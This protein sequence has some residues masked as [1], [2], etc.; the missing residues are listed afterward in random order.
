MEERPPVKFE[1]R[2]SQTGK[3]IEVT[4]ILCYDEKWEENGLW[5]VPFR[6]PAGELKVVFTPDKELV[7]IRRPLNNA[8]NTANDSLISA[9]AKIGYSGISYRDTISQ[10]Q[11][12]TICGQIKCAQRGISFFPGDLQ[13]PGLTLPENII[14]ELR[15]RDEIPRV[16]ILPPVLEDLEGF[17]LNVDKQINR[18]SSGKS[19]LRDCISDVI[20]QAPDSRLAKIKELNTAGPTIP[21]RVYPDKKSV[22]AIAKKLNIEIST[23][24]MIDAEK[25]REEQ[26]EINIPEIGSTL[27]KLF[28]KRLQLG[29]KSQRL[30]YLDPEASYQPLTDFPTVTG[31]T[32]EEIISGLPSKEYRLEVPDNDY[33]PG[34]ISQVIWEFLNSRAGEIRHSGSRPS[35]GENEKKYLDQ[36]R[37]CVTRGLPVE[38]IFMNFSPKFASPLISGYSLLPDLSNLMAL[39]HLIDVAK[40]VQEIY[41]PGIKFIIL[42]EGRL[43]QNLGQFTDGEAHESLEQVKYFSRVL[44]GK[45]GVSGVIEIADARESVD[46]LGA[47]FMN[48]LETEEENLDRAYASDEDG[49]FIRKIEEWRTAFAMNIID[50]DRLIREYGEEHPPLALADWLRVIHHT[51]PSGGFL[52]RVRHYADQRTRST[53]IDYFAFR[54][55][56]YSGGTG[57]R[58][59]LTDY[60][61]AIPITVRADRS[62]LSL[63]LI[64]GISSYPHHGITVWTGEK[65]EITG[66]MDLARYPG[67][68]EG[69]TLAG[70]NAPGRTPFYYTLKGVDCPV[71][72]RPAKD[73]KQDG[74][75][76][77]IL[78]KKGFRML[79][80]W[81]DRG[82]MDSRLYLAED[83]SGTKV[84]IKYSS[85]EGFGGN[86]R[87]VLRKEALRLKGISEQMGALSGSIFPEVIEYFDDEN[88]TYYVMNYFSDTQSVDDYLAGLPS[89]ESYSAEAGRLVNKLLDIMSEKVY[90]R[91]TETTPPDYISR[92]HLDR[93]REGVQ[94]LI[95]DKSSIFVDF[96]K[97][98]IFKAGGVEYK[99]VTDFFRK[100]FSNE[101]VVVNGVELLN[102]PSI[103]RAISDNEEAIN[104]ALNPE[105]IPKI[106]HGD[107]YFRNVL[108]DPDGELFLVDPYGKRPVNA[109]ETELGRLMLSYFADFLG[110]GDYDINVRAAEDGKLDFSLFYNGADDDSIRG[111]A[112]A[113]DAMLEIYGN[114]PGIYSWIKNTEN[115]QAHVLLLEAIHIF[116]VAASKFSST[117]PP[118]KLTLA[119]YIT[120]LV[121][122]NKVLADMGLIDR[123]YGS[124]SSPMELF[125]PGEY[126]FQTV[127]FMRR[128]APGANEADGEK[129]LTFLIE[130]F[131]KAGKHG[132]DKDTYWELWRSFK[133][134]VDD[135]IATD[136]YMLDLET[137]KVMILTLKDGR[138]I[139][140]RMVSGEFTD[141]IEPL[142]ALHIKGGSKLEI[143]HADDALK[144]WQNI[145]FPDTSS[146]PDLFE[147]YSEKDMFESLRNGSPVSFG[148]KSYQ[149]TDLLGFGKESKVFKAREIETGREV[150]LKAGLT[151]LE[152]ESSD[153]GVMTSK[154]KDSTF[155]GYFPSYELFDKEKNV[156]VMELIKGEPLDAHITQRLE[157]GES[158]EK[159]LLLFSGIMI[160]IC[161]MKEKYGV[162]YGQF[163]LRNILIDKKGDKRFI[164]PSYPLPRD[165]YDLLQIIRAGAIMMEKFYG[166]RDDE[167]PPKVKGAAG[168]D[169]LKKVRISGSIWE[170]FEEAELPVEPMINTKIK[171][172]IRKCLVPDTRIE[173]LRDLREEL[174]GLCDVIYAYHPELRPAALH[175]GAARSI[176]QA[177]LKEY[178]SK[179]YKALAVDYNNTLEQDGATDRYLM[180]KIAELLEQDIHVAVIT[181]RRATWINTFVEEIRPFLPDEDALKRLHFYTSEG[182][183]GCNVGTRELYYEHAFDRNLMVKTAKVIKKE[184]PRLDFSVNYRTDGYRMNFDPIMDVKRLNE[185]FE[186]LGLPVIALTSG[187]SIDVLP[188]GINKGVA[189]ADFAARLGISIAD[190]ARIADQGQKYGNDNSLLSGPGS[191]SVDRCE[192]DSDQAGTAE[193]LGLKGIFATA[194]LLDNLRFHE[195]GTDHR[196]ML[197][198]D[199][200]REHGW[201]SKYADGSL[202]SDRKFV[203][204]AVKRH[205]WALRYADGSLQK[206][207]EIVLA[208]V[209][210]FGLALQYAGGSLRNDKEIVM[211]A[212]KTNRSAFKHADESLK[213]D[214][215]FVLAVVKENGRALEHADELLRND[216][217]I[218]LAAAIR[219][220]R[221]PAEYA[222]RSLWENRDFVLAQVKKD[223]SALECAAEPLKSDK[224]IV[225]TAVKQNRWA[226]RYAHGSLREDREVVLAGVR[227][228]G[229]DLASADESLW[230]DKEF[231]LSVLI[232]NG[233]AFRF[234][235]GSLKKDRDFVLAAV[236]VNGWALKYADG[237][238]RKD[239]EI[240]LAAVKG[241]GAALQ[242][243]D[244]SLRKDKEIVVT[245]VTDNG[246]ALKFADGSLKG[247]QDI[248]RAAKIEAETIYGR[249]APPVQADGRSLL[250]VPDPREDPFSKDN[251][252]E[253]NLLVAWS[254]GKDGCLA[255]HRAMKDKNNRLAC[256]LNFTSRQSA[257]VSFH[258]IPPKLLQMQVEALGVPLLQAETTPDGY[259]EE[260]KAAV[261][262][263]V[264]PH[265]IDAMVFGDIYVDEHKEWVGQVCEDAGIQAIEPLW[266]ENTEDLLREIID[267]GFEVRIVSV[268]DG[269]IDKKWVGRKIDHEFLDH[270][271]ERGLDP[272][273]EYGEYHSFVTDGPIFTRRIELL[274]TSVVKRWKYW[275][276]DI[277]KYRSVPKEQG[278]SSPAAEEKTTSKIKKETPPAAGTQ[279]PG[280]FVD[281]KQEI[282]DLI[283]SLQFTENQPALRIRTIKALAA[284]NR[285]P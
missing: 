19:G 190:I 68:F 87:P 211:E 160:D 237:A 92:F 80:D 196:A 234:A 73:Q 155:A 35:Y 255:L 207:R 148:G 2:S 166:L 139:G 259:Q 119:C 131:E 81:S 48:E 223:G 53:A 258:E 116:V 123:K 265:E 108:R 63:Q 244:T 270:L 261:S 157:A 262:S 171:E 5:V 269:L 102:F 90:S 101:T 106:T 109:V 233:E 192:S 268:K 229:W 208:A 82:A 247:D 62:R 93:L 91:G 228:H 253:R 143:I 163:N 284:C 114:H 178:T 194:W 69:V 125:I 226:L 224:E 199:T 272:C 42:Y 145:N 75:F 33:S 221:W 11:S 79:E 44:E 146:A 45:A 150:A 165:R 202:W 104:R 193:A 115:W 201:P 231:I 137:Y 111:R 50:L 215:E 187:T 13:R 66:L 140:V 280:L 7:E 88:A 67:Q 176:A 72:A 51:P 56:K 30:D 16:L 76:P 52:D 47:G 84:I 9:L 74:S 162:F 169:E 225:L 61:R 271:K 64:P 110:R 149:V 98:R 212:V 97:D 242:F 126:G 203:L 179:R 159:L 14:E 99:N 105:R 59:I 38:L 34:T 4:G 248:L 158:L 257:R 70:K 28:M 241:N 217:E 273:G 89:G 198:A 181:G 219:K 230:S 27:K 15:S 281:P 121:L 124:V 25:A 205:G 239:R 60:P 250:A 100:A 174:E 24:Q 222:D 254:G 151:G 175:A 135:D 182:A 170:R 206:D 185:L 122:M 23:V 133:T 197:L 188:G 168:L 238:L 274:D 49:E 142:E 32:F 144:M 26:F 245:A 36:I 78:A 20:V 147:G 65:W 22:K 86:G 232:E 256:L 130:S 31:P 134:Q 173:T 227:R 118:G 277:N 164:D 39:Q 18:V 209:K 210:Q 285:I 243:A 17:L 278:K 252:S 41:P 6:F 129:L 141:Q 120:G 43:Y 249:R 200:V 246:E 189:L 275:V 240:V 218:V 29:D 71:F 55:V 3:K 54:N 266:N 267:A 172:I 152:N 283:Q 57:K 156:I 161:L 40:A 264:V 85:E 154:L 191:F 37:E 186:K 167:Y 12:K 204:A 260:Y 282:R 8:G 112:K 180:R 94:L 21:F 107:L 184:Y 117:D 136:Q 96:L 10:G 177:R 263:L 138:K 276:L 83:G 127:R 220:H 251:R 236:R 183:K 58:G 132:R 195:P 153:A 77:E 213:K 279:N 216:R 113:R 214:R 128:I 235:D 95:D 103:L 46:A 1:V